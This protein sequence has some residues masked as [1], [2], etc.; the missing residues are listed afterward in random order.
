LSTFILKV[1]SYLSTYTC[2]FL[3]VE[4]NSVLTCVYLFIKGEESYLFTKGE[5]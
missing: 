3:T 5:G 4:N 1:I 2:N